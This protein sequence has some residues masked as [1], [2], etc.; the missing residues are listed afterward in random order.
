MWMDVDGDDF[1]P[2]KAGC[3]ATSINKPLATKEADA[4]NVCPGALTLTSACQV[5]ILLAPAP[6]L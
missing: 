4:V 5:F 2:M 6:L 3:I 1:A